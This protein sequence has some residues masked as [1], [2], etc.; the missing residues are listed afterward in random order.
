M[1]VFIAGC[2]DR[3]RGLYGLALGTRVSFV[4]AA[5]GFNVQIQRSL[6]VACFQLLGHQ[7]Q[8]AIVRV[9]VVPDPE[10]QCVSCLYVYA[11]ERQV[12]RC[13]N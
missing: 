6:P 12:R 13:G 9:S 10:T 3:H 1:Q 5:I 2:H 4:L 8:A 7:I 11:H